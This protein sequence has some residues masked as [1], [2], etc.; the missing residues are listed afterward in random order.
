MTSLIGALEGVSPGG[1]GGGGGVGDSDTPLSP[2][3]RFQPAEP[4]CSMVHCYIRGSQASRIIVVTTV[5][6]G[7]GKLRHHATVPPRMN[8]LCRTFSFGELSYR[9]EKTSSACP[10]NNLPLLL[11]PLLLGMIVIRKNCSPILSINVP[12]CAVVVGLTVLSKLIF[13]RTTNKVY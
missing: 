7:K 3:V 13:Y 6:V 11:L 1:S 8:A 4:Q 5:V 9:G 12:C 2:R 10:A